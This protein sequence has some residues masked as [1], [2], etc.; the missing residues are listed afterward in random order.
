MMRRVVWLIASLVVCY[1]SFLLA[2]NILRVATPYTITTLDWQGST[3]AS[4]RRIGWHI[5]E[6]LVCYDEQFNVIPQLAESYEISDDSLRYVFHL[7]KGVQFHK[8]YGE[9]TAEDVKASLERF[10]RYGARAADFSPVSAVTVIDSYTVEIMLREPCPLLGL[11]ASPLAFPAIMP[12]ELA[13]LPVREL[14]VSQVVGTG[15]FELVEYVPGEKLILRKFDQYSMDTRY[16]GPNGMGGKRTAYFDEVRIYFVLDAQTRYAGLLTGEYD[17][18]NDPP[19]V[20]LD[21]IK[22]DPRFSWGIRLIQKSICNFNVKCPPTDNLAVRHA[23]MRAL[24]MD[25]ILLPMVQGRSE[26][27]RADSSLFAAEGPWWYPAAELMGVWGHKSRVEEARRLLQVAGY[28]GEKVIIVAGTEQTARAGEV[29]VQQLKQAGINAELLVFDWATAV[30]YRTSGT[31]PWNIFLGGATQHMFDPV[32]M[33]LFYYGSTSERLWFYRNP[34]LDALIERADSMLDFNARVEAYKEIQKFI[35]AD[36]PCFNIGDFAIWAAW[37]ARL[38]GPGLKQ[39]YLD[40]F[41]DIYWGS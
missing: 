41:W 33:R 17:Y 19:Y 31:Q 2:A 32:T 28:H 23:I 14:G 22:G 16:A 12:A 6:G 11:L 26:L 10:F 25:E 18:V 27:C 24:G 4:L 34:T 35:A 21:S 15:P 9:M 29:M 13:A 38:Q 8:G 5:W 36:L 1:S 39:W 40:R 37:D 3:D 30:N 7:R 20:A